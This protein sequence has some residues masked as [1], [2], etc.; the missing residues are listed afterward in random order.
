VQGDGAGAQSIQQCKHFFNRPGGETLPE[1]G[2]IYFAGFWP[3]QRSCVA[4]QELLFKAAPR[5]SKTVPNHD[6]LKP[7]RVERG[8]FN[9]LEQAGLVLGAS[10]LK[11]DGG[12]GV[13]DVHS[14]ED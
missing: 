10:G 7:G 5:I 12:D 4:T 11:C 14:L 8:G 9:E 1:G 6:G 13:F 3:N 2:F